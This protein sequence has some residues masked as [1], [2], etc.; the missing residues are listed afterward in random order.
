MDCKK[1]M[2]FAG[3]VAGVATALMAVSM[4]T[5]ASVVA[6]V[7]LRCASDGRIHVDVAAIEAMQEE[8]IVEV[9]MGRGFR[10][11][12]FRVEARH[13]VTEGVAWWR[14]RAVDGTLANATLVLRDGFVAAGVRMPEAGL[15]WLLRP[16]SASQLVPMLMPEGYLRCG[17]TD[18][19]PQADGSVESGS[20]A[21]GIE[22]ASC[23]A[24]AADVA[25]FYTSLALEG[26]ELELESLGGD[27]D[28]APMTFA[29]KIQLECATTS[30]AF[31]NTDLPYSVVPVYIGVID[32]DEGA[33][34]QDN[35]GW[36]LDY[37][38]GAGSELND[39]IVQKRIDVG[40]DSTSLITENPPGWAAGI[41]GPGIT[42]LM[43]GYLGGT[44]FAHEFGHD[45]G[46]NHAYGDGNPGW[47]CESSNAGDP[48]RMPCETID[49]GGFNF[50]WRFYGSTTLCWRTVM[51][52]GP[53]TGT[54]SYSNPEVIYDGTPTGVPVGDPHQADAYTFLNVSFPAVTAR[55]CETP[56][57]ES[58]EGRL[59][60]AGGQEYDAFGI[61][62]AGVVETFVGGASLH[63]SRAL[64]AGAA[65][66]FEWTLED[67][68]DPADPDD[69][70]PD[71]WE[72]TAKLMPTFL[73]E[74]D[75]FGEAVAMD[76]DL[77]VIAAPRAGLWET[78]FDKEGK[79]YE[80]LAVQNAGLVTVWERSGAE[81]T[82]CLVD[83][84]QPSSLKPFDWFG[85]SVDVHNGRIAI[86]CP[87]RDSNAELT[88]D[89]GSVFVYSVDGGVV[90]LDDERVGTV[91]GATLG[92]AVVIHEHTETGNWH[93]L[94]GA[95]KASS[96]RGEVVSWTSFSDDTGTFIE[97]ETL[98]GS[99]GGTSRFG[100][101]IA[102]EQNALAVGAP[103]ALDNVGRVHTYELSNLSWLSPE[104][105]EMLGDDEEA[106]FGN[107]IAING[108][109]L[110]VGAPRS[111]SPVLDRLG[112]VVVFEQIE[113]GSDWVLTD[114]LR[115]T[116]LRAGDELGASVAMSG[117]II[118]AG[119]PDADDD[120]VLSGVVYAMESE[121]EDC[122]ENK[123]DDAIDVYLGTSADLNG[124]G[125]PDECENVGCDADLNGDGIVNGNDLG[126]LLEA[127][128]P[129]ELGHPAD[130]ND[131][132]YVNGVDIGVFFA[133]WGFECDPKEP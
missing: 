67:L 111:A 21:G 96:N 12:R 89:V 97:L 41:G 56:E 15:E 13:D 78:K 132:G 44:L 8:D 65:Y 7:D 29:A 98:S 62:I 81:G 2:M 58:Q 106:L 115:P 119:A 76:G 75:R 122:N 32:Y 120:G 69:D 74:G 77:L 84:I 94:A 116:G 100:T 18:V 129:V 87:R 1:L 27:P 38:A 14:L 64:D 10:V 92:S 131:D 54:L 17:T 48:C 101:A 95:P 104:T 112:A 114:F 133:A 66:V 71:R 127:W 28:D 128:G 102:L 105:L 25:F 61:A 5:P 82:Y 6:P 107:S 70:L 85:S 37:L 19:I 118:F 79:P 123:I 31:E 86:G 46:L 36:F 113:V 90:S 72:Q 99:I 26:E 40:G 4:D 23:S 16:M 42:H 34:D 35:V 11:E 3:C 43:R 108:S 60:A 73:H 53:G 24:L 124:N 30:T 20:V 130:L 9:S 109:R 63:D 22:C 103:G 88:N 125:V 39:E 47:D 126:L 45:C 52:Y 33:F 91:V 57:F 59:A 49:T 110:S 80:V 55:A 68:G 93:L 51:A 117:N 121:L 83:T 50:G